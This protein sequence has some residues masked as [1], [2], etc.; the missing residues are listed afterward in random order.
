MLKKARDLETDYL[1]DL[2][3]TDIYGPNDERL[4][5]VGDGLID[6]VSGNLR[7][8]LV[9][10]G[11][12]K[13]RRFLL[14]AD[15]VYAFGDSNNLYANLRQRDIEVLP[16]FHE[17]LLV[18]D[19]AFTT[20]ESEYRRNWRYNADPNHMR[21]SSVLG[22]FRDRLHNRYAKERTVASR[23]VAPVADVTTVGARPTVVYGVYGDREAAEK[24]VD[25]LRKDGF[26]SGDISVVFPDRDLN[27]EF[28]IEK[29][30]KAPEGALTGGG[31]GLVVGGALGWLVGIGTLAIP[32]VG[33]LI[34]AGPI[35][36][37][38]TGVGVGTAVGGIA[39]ALI[40][41]GLPE[42][43]AKR[44]EE[45]IKRGRILVSVHC[46]SVGVAHTAR[47]ALEET[48]GKAVFLSGE[49]RAA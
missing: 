42:L 41:L 1:G 36:A 12:L 39:G 11:W 22:R 15:Q 35:I 29:H 20:Y 48:G 7:Y 26:N 9:D 43:E 23:D 38:L 25:Y 8:L 45:E 4:G 5:T 37:A 44:Y 24:A 33:P 19:A 30:T 3:G 10:A 18:S 16:E 13:S 27:K 6:D 32:G 2:R 31:A 14:P 47:K 17:S 46:A 21:P 34:A 28:S 40:G 49:Q